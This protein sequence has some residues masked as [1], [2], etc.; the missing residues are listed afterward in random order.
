MN[1]FQDEIEKEAIERIQKFEA[2]A[3]KMGLEVC[4]GFSGGKDSQVTYD[5]CIR[6]GINFKAYFNH[7]FESGVTMK[8]I[9]DFYPKVIWRRDHK[10]GF[11]ENI[12]KN[13]K[14]ILPTVTMA[15]C[16]QDYKHN[17]K[18]VDD[19]SITGVR[20]AESQRRKKRT[21]FEA[22]NKTML[23]KNKTLVDSYFQENCQSV[24][25]ASLIQLKPI[26]DWSDSDVWDYIK[27]HNIPINPEYSNKRRVGCIVCPKANLTSNYVTL[28]D[29]PKIID[30]FIKAIDAGGSNDWIIQSESKDC[31]KDKTYYICRWL[32]H[33]FMPF[34]KKQELL[35]QE[36][37]DNY[38]KYKQLNNK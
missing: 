25:A 32:N 28:K 14:G 30:A 11:L 1:I 23:K 16:C 6:S 31:S 26:I 33:S 5:L 29:N 20:K 8:F 24:G 18:Y 37:I 34:S 38:N 36:I 22:K 35:Y 27:R 4:V 9:K 19:C 15:Y 21:A 13:Y 3:K 7:S 2:I 17:P 12:K 10:F